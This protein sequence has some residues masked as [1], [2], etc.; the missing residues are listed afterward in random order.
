[1]SD[2]GSGHVVGV[3]VGGKPCTFQCSPQTGDL[4]GLL[5]NLLGLVLDLDPQIGE[6][7]LLGVDQ[8]VLLADAPFTFSG[9]AFLGVEF[10][11]D[12]LQPL[13]DPIDRP[14]GL[15]EP[16]RENGDRLGVAVEL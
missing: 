6:L 5:V 12:R 8:L 16:R 10:G 3:D 11:F 4:V 15:F 9:L 7:H 14:V 2:R 13:G 1:M